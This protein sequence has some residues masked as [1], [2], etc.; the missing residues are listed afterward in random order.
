M[1]SKDEGAGAA[2]RDDVR[3]MR[4]TLSRDNLEEKL[5]NA[6][7][8]RPAI[9]PFLDLRL[10]AIAVG[11]AAVLTLIAAVVVSVGAGAIVLVLSF[12]ATWA[13]LA[14]RSYDKRRPTT[15]VERE[16]DAEEGGTDPAPFSG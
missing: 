10:V 11:I 7:E 5:E 14:M 12:F 6:V 13:I 1:A 15:V 3:Q 4:E 8:E 9:E 2:I 16:K